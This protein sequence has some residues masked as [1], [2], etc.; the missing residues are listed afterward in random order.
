M[1]MDC[2]CCS[3]TPEGVEVKIEASIV[4]VPEQVDMRVCGPCWG[5]VSR[6]IDADVGLDPD[7]LE[8]AAPER[9]RLGSLAE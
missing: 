7:E 1:I 4:G 3:R 2:D 8:Y 6:V 5:M 9:S